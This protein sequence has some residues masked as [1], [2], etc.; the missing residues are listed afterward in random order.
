MSFLSDSILEWTRI[1]VWL[2]A[3]FLW[4]WNAPPL[5]N[6]GSFEEQLTN[7]SLRC[8]VWPTPKLNHSVVYIRHCE[9][10]TICLSLRLILRCSLDHQ[11]FGS[12]LLPA[13][14]WCLWPLFATLII[15]SFEL[16]YYSN[17]ARA[18]A[19]KFFPTGRY[20]SM[21]L[22][23]LKYCTH[24]ACFGINFWGWGFKDSKF[25]WS[26]QTSNGVFPLLGN[27]SKL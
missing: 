12:S 6:H 23:R 27:V 14:G 5:L 2:E 15:S 10:G 18:S 4:T 3:G 26:V 9:F 17:L 1:V 21:K 16:L 8:T 7:G 11:L 25:L 19:R 13:L 22:N 24:Q 20:H